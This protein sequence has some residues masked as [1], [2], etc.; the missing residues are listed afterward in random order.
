MKTG[1]AETTSGVNWSTVHEPNQGRLIM[2]M[3]QTLIGCG[4]C[5]SSKTQ[6]QY[7]ENTISAMMN[8][9]IITLSLPRASLFIMTSVS[10]PARTSIPAAAANEQ[11][12]HI[13]SKILGLSVHTYER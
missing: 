8:V 13:V 1:S 3:A 4:L 2:V 5:N 9:Q 11:I 7:Q 10:Q 12:F 6:L